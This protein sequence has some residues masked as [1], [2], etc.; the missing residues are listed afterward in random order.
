MS[1]QVSGKLIVKLLIL[2][3]LISILRLERHELI[4]LWFF[5]ILNLHVGKCFEN[6]GG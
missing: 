3:A 4:G 1:F 2:L 6:I 5:F